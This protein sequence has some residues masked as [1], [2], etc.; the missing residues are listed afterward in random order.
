MYKQYDF[1]Q[2]KLMGIYKHMTKFIEISTILLT[3]RTFKKQ[4][5]FSM[6]ATNSV[7]YK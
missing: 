4:L 7:K 5:H 3:T 6:P 2:R 1:L